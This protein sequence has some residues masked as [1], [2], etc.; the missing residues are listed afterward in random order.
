M[1]ARAATSARACSYVMV[2]ASHCLSSSMARAVGRMSSMAMMARARDAADFLGI[3]W[4]VCHGAREMAKASRAA[5]SAL[6]LKHCVELRQ[7]VR[8]AIA[9][10]PSRICAEEH[11][12]TVSHLFCSKRRIDTGM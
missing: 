10:N 6:L 12:L 8:V 1:R 2:P 3:V 9:F 11:L 4:P 5:C 7:F